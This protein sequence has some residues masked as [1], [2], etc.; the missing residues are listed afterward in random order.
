MMHLFRRHPE[1]KPAGEMHLVAGLGNPGRQYERT[2]HNIGFMVVDR[3]AEQNGVH[4]SKSKHEA[5]VARWNLDDLTIFLAKPLTFMNDSGYAI[6]RLDR[7]YHVPAKQV[8]VICDDMDLPFGTMRLRPGGSSGGQRGL[9]SVIQV[10][11]TSDIPRLRLGVDRPESSSVKH[12]LDRFPPEEERSL[13]ALLDIAADAVTAAL[14]EGV[15]PAMNRFNR[16]WTEDL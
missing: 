2:R 14:T 10:L 13:S 5:D 11:G 6:G 12:V 4:W 3:L 1:P 9:Q 15:A 7:Y 16:D 8:L